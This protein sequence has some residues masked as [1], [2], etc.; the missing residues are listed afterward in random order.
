MTKD[1]KTKNFCLV[2]K[3]QKRYENWK[4]K[5][6]TY[7]K[8]IVYLRKRLKESMI[9]GDKW[10]S[11]YYALKAD[12]ALLQKK[13]SEIE[14]GLEKV[15]E[16][17][18][19]LEII[20]FSIWL[21]S[22]SSISLDG[23]RKVLEVFNKVFDFNYKIPCKETI[24]TWEKKHSY[25]RLD[26]IKTE[27][28]GDWAAIID[29][30]ITIGEEKI[31]LVLGVPLSLYKFGESLKFTDIKVLQISISKSWKA[32]AISKVLND[33]L[34]IGYD[35]KY[36]ISDGCATLNC[37]ITKSNLEKVPDCTHAF[38]NILK[39]EYEQLEE[40][41]SFD[42][43]CNILKKQTN[44]GAN[45]IISPPK[46]RAKGKFLNLWE[47]SKWS[48][49]M[50][51]IMELPLRRRT[52]ILSD[53]M[54]DR[55]KFITNYKILIERLFLQCEVINELHKI[56]KT[57]G[58]SEESVKDCRKILENRYQ[59]EMNII[60]KDFTLKT[61]SFRQKIETYFS[62]GLDLIKELN[63]PTIICTSDII[64]SMFGKYKE[65]VR[66]GSQSVTDDCLNMANFTGEFS[67]IETK[68]AMENTKIVD[69]ENWRKKN[70][71]DSLRAKKQKLHK[72]VG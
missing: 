36:V 64:E 20:M 54:Q 57:N 58:L 7:N 29:E 9:R 49:S 4:L 46:Y 28:T 51:K 59:Q 53:S 19:P 44:I 16:H 32:D 72:N 3:I 23:V 31:L 10:R 52:K 17:S 2:S 18:Y 40:Y 41:K 65:R 33:L 62:Q 68:E 1:N 24:R 47:K 14:V 38:G 42:K 50:L 43:A 37:A 6:V 60:Q 13:S 26:S 15:A 8:K 11:R 34:S 61:D 21:R 71:K 22:S 69:I 39:S 45:A 67:R 12:Y 56:L 63:L 35:I 48:N 66:K 25:Y 55:L 70:C 27:V 5:A 30:S